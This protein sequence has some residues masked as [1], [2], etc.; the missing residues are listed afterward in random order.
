MFARLELAY[1]L[2][3]GRQVLCSSVA[4][5]LSAHFA[6]RSPNLHS[7]P[8]TLHFDKL[9]GDL[10]NGGKIEFNRAIAAGPLRAG[11]SLSHGKLESE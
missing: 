3:Y 4:H 6:E 2:S 10:F 8:Q 5:F 9:V 1:C 11:P 7:L